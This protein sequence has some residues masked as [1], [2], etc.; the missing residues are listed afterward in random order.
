[1]CL[2]GLSKAGRVVCWSLFPSRP[3]VESSGGCLRTIRWR[4]PGTFQN[5]A[6]AHPEC[7]GVPQRELPRITGTY[8]ISEQSPHLHLPPSR[9]QTRLGRCRALLLC[10]CLCVP[11]P[12]CLTT[13]VL[14]TSVHSFALWA[15]LTCPRRARSLAARTHVLSC[16]YAKYG[17][18]IGSSTDV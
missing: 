15:A 16:H 18:P 7:L 13:G 17:S 12:L 2:Q 14:Y 3:V 5:H 1:M 8:S 4:T 6:S 10:K 9:P 11:I